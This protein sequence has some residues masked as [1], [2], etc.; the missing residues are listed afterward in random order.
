MKNDGLLTYRP[1]VFWSW[2]DRLT[3]EG[4]KRQFDDLQ[5]AGIAGGFLHSRVG[6]VT[7]YCSDEWM[8]MVDYT[9][10]LAKEK[11][12]EIWLYDE[13]R[14][15]SGYAGG[16]VLEED[17][18]LRAK[19]LCLIETERCEEFNVLNEY[20]RLSFGGKEY[21]IALCA[22]K[23]GNPNFEGK[24]YVDLLDRRATECFIR[25][26]HEV[27]KK[28]VGN[29]FGKQIKGIFSDEFCYTQ[30]AAFACPSVPFTTNLEK[31]FYENLGYDL[32]AC[33]E[34]LFF[35]LEDY[36][37]IR[38]DFYEFLT[39][40]F[41]ESYTKPV[42][43]WCRENNLIFTGHLLNEDFLTSQVEWIGAAMPH[44][45]YM[46]MPGVDKL[47][48]DRAYLTTVKQ[49]TSVTEQLGKRALCEAFACSGHQFGPGGIKRV[50]DWLCALGIN[51]INPHLTQFSMRGERKRDCP[52][53]ISARQPWF[54]PAGKDC[55]EHIARVC[56]LVD[57]ETVS[58]K[59]LV[60][61]PIQSV[62][63]EYSPLHKPNPVFSIWSPKNPNAGQNFITET[64]SFEKPFIDI[65]EKLQAEGLPFH[66]GDE[67]IMAESAA[68]TD[69]GLRIG[70]CVYSTVVVPPVCVLG[71]ATLNLLRDMAERFGKE[72]VIFVRSFPNCLSPDSANNY[73][74]V[75]RTDDAVNL[76]RRRISPEVT[77]K[78]RFTGRTAGQI[79]WR[80]TV[81]RLSEENFFFANTDAK[82]EVRAQIV[83]P[84]SFV[85]T[86]Y[87]TVADR[88]GRAPGVLTDK[89]FFMEL[90]F[91]IGGSLVVL[92]K[93]ADGEELFSL[94]SGVTLNNRQMRLIERKTAPVGA[95]QNGNLL[96]LDV[97]DYRADGKEILNTPIEFLWHNSFYRLKNGT[98]FEAIYPFTVNRLPEKPLL[99]F[100]E[101]GR[102]LEEISLNG[103]PLERITVSRPMFLDDTFDAYV[104]DFLKVG[105]NRIVIKGNK[106]NNINGV[107][108][109]TRVRQGDRHLPTELEPIF[110]YGDFQTVE[111]EK[112][113][114]SVDIGDNIVCGSTTDCG[115]PF[116]SG[117]VRYN[118][119]SV[120]G[121]N[122]VRICADAQC[123][124]IFLN[125]VLAGSSFLKPF[126]FYLSSPLKAGDCLEVVLHGSLENTFGP[127]HLADRTS[128]SLIGPIYFSDPARY[129]KKP[130]LF[131][132]GLRSVEILQ[133]IEGE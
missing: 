49:L 68:L 37:R 14:F 66:Y 47:G 45:P 2:N 92:A 132:F 55:F 18:S 94:Q 99:I 69:K 102:N 39:R 22:A 54:L 116:Y 79:Y 64:E 30:K 107:G 74:L 90:D 112:G 60:L 71:E 80:H 121:G 106:C 97:V 3:K 85:P 59:A 63:A 8:E 70:N 33:V 11:K 103:E 127:L 108:S 13:D 26:T 100:V 95:T 123:V 4:I 120:Q 43:S 122:I 16:A 75:S 65:S 73:T 76:L 83:L 89:G 93:P 5:K 126:E 111:T 124:Q 25:H 67:M 38:R 87:D 32:M 119:G 77:V 109:H 31:D 117:S 15:P 36:R 48:S 82:R 61:H 41:I 34:Q 133:T 56:S 128:L 88:C 86:V 23:D 131:D 91:K 101:M 24:C 1:V 58:E 115:Y 57:G 110:L 125:G 17:D 44:Y 130:I 98:P 114:Y 105:K 78:D 46:G 53:D 20:K 12:T 10:K 7:E 51:F 113:C 9:A 29:Y 50:S 35:D 27:Y 40:R 6:L 28:W 104:A 21:L 42:E 129:V 96:P 62:W 81:N 84:L 118:L 19:A 52:P 72:S